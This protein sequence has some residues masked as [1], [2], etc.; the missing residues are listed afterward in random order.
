MSLSRPASPFLGGIDLH[1]GVGSAG[2]DQLLGAG[3]VHQ[4][5]LHRAMHALGDGSGQ[6]HHHAAGTTVL[7][8]TDRRQGVIAQEQGGTLRDPGIRGPRQGLGREGP[9]RRC[10]HQQAK[11]DRTQHSHG[12]P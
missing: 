2:L 11:R 1:E 10:G 5:D 7:H 8:E 12:C 4:P 6:I 9:V 3:P